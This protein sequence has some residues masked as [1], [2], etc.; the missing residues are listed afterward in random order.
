LLRMGENSLGSDNSGVEP[1]I[2]K[3]PCRRVDLCV[4]Q[5]AIRISL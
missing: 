5:S 2:I 1:K 3:S 4:F